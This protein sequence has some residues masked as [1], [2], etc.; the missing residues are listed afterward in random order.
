MPCPALSDTSPAFCPVYPSALPCPLPRPNNCPSLPSLSLCPPLPSALRS[1]ACCPLNSRV[2]LC[3][4]PSPAYPLLPSPTLCPP[5]TSPASCLVKR[6]TFPYSLP[7]DPPTAVPCP[8][9][10]SALPGPLSSDL[11][12][13]LPYP[14]PSPARLLPS[15][16]RSSF[17]H[18]RQ[19]APSMSPPALCPE[20][21]FQQTR[22]ATPWA[23]AHLQ[24][25]T[26]RVGGEVLKRGCGKGVV[27]ARR[28]WSAAAEAPGGHAQRL[29][30]PLGV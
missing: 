23:R 25:F 19:V 29:P 28:G 16:L 4:L 22:H 14:L 2:L 10:A 1:S 26:R 12:S 21:H 8:I 17:Q 27:T 30:S 20:I 6:S 5:L 11:P 9:K 24:Q 7:S 13:A 18:T 3:P 15:A